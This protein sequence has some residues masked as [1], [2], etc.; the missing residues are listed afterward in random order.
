[1]TYAYFKGYKAEYDNEKQDWFYTD[2]GESATL[3]PRPCKECRNNPTEEGFDYC[4]G[5]LGE[6]VVSACCG[7]GV[8]KGY[9]L[10]DDG[11]LF[12][13]VLE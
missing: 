13:E 6:N 1:M 7:H 2:T 5:N 8:K 3:N 9:I 12:E 4:L 10:F 11:R